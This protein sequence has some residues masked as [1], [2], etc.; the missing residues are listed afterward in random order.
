M[1]EVVGLAASIITLALV[2]ETIIKVSKKIRKASKDASLVKGDM[3]QRAVLFEASGRAIEAS[4]SVLSRLRIHHGESDLIGDLEHRGVFSSL[5]KGINMV[6]GR[7]KDFWREIRSVESRFSLI[8]AFKWQS[9]K[10]GVTGL[11]V[12]IE[13]VKTTILMV[14]VLVNLECNMRDAARTRDRVYRARLKQ[15]K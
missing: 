2:S 3:S 11:S 14:M 12:Q 7:L 9:C 6:L 8:T 10:E 15:E 5:E 13:C 1:A 4:Y